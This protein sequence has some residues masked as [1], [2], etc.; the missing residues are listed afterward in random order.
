MER[1]LLALLTAA[2]LVSCS[3][4]RRDAAMPWADC[5]QA[6]ALAWLG[7]DA[8]SA[9]PIA[10]A[11]PAGTPIQRVALGPTPPDAIHDALYRTLHLVPSQN[12]V[13]VEHTGGFAGVH[14]LYGPIPL[15]G[16]CPAPESH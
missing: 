14:A 1:I 12:A 9:L 4:T 11:L 13:Y 3:T 5:A 16:H 8:R 10:Q 6:Q 7:S 2:V 15:A